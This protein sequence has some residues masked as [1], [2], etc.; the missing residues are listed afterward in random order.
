[1]A[2]G[3]HKI[4]TS[5]HDRMNRWLFPSQHCPRRKIT[6]YCWSIRVQKLTALG[7]RRKL[8]GTEQVPRSPI[9]LQ[10]R[11]RPILPSNLR[12]ST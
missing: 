10:G 6:N 4:I 5:G 7:P 3:P 11:S 9:W 2:D 12:V 8:S 1:M